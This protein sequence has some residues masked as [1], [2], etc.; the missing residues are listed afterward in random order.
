M[1]L[2][3]DTGQDGIIVPILE[4][5]NKIPVCVAFSKSLSHGKFE[6][7]KQICFSSSKKSYSHLFVS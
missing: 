4:A 5:L 3:S 7:L 1:L 2:I 6:T